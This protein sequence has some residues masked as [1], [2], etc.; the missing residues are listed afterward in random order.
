MTEE[1]RSKFIIN[2]EFVEPPDGIVVK[3]WVF[4]GEP[5]FKSKP[6][7]KKLE[8]LVL[9]ETAGRT[10]SGC[11]NTLLKKKHGVQLILDR[12]GTVSTHG[13][14]ALDVMIHANQVNG[15]SIGIEVVNPYAPKLAKGMKGIRTIPAKWWTW[16]ADKMD[17]SYVLPTEEQLRVL[18]ILIP[19]LCEK[20][21]IPYVCPTK[22]LNS[23]MPK[24]KNW[25][26]RAKPKPGVIAHRDFATHAD[27]RYLLEYLIEHTNLI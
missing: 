10:A 22:N 13:D 2:D 16:I 4:D 17:E 14:L 11:K 6:R 25:R 5:L 1:A 12:D 27:G 21:G 24:I 18:V 7:K 20:L 19:W 15:T 9:H 8:H 23:R 26:L 3:N